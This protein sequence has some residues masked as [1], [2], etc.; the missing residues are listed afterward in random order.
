MCSLRGTSTASLFQLNNVLNSLASKVET[1]PIGLIGEFLVGKK[2]NDVFTTEQLISVTPRIN[3]DDSILLKYDREQ[4]I[5]QLKPLQQQGTTCGAHAFKNLLWMINGLSG[6]LNTFIE[7]YL[8]ILDIN[9]FDNYFAAGVCQKYKFI[10]FKEQKDDVRENK[11]SCILSDE[12]LP[13]NSINYLDQMFE[14]TY[15]PQ[16]NEKYVGHVGYEWSKFFNFAKEELKK[17]ELKADID[18]IAKDASVFLPSFNSDDIMKFYNQLIKSDFCLGIDLSV[19]NGSMGHAT[20]LMAHKI[21]NKTEYLFLDSMNKPFDGAYPYMPLI[22]SVKG[23]I[24]NPEDFKNALIRKAYA[25]VLMYVDQGPFS[26]FKIHLNVFIDDQ[27]KDLNLVD[28]ELYQTYKPHFCKI[29]KTYMKKDLAKK[30]EYEKIL[31]KMNC[32][33]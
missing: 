15:A 30:S 6:S 5:Y 24:E 33:L 25:N 20:C 29:I 14:F 32:A 27:F 10:P 17:V 12:C 28:S 23:F 21:R 7:S 3:R 16:Y 8:K 26:V 11:I 31:K 9:I 18:T 2:Y 1:S 13:K 4:K 19:D 22:E